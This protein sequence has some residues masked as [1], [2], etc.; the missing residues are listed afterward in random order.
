MTVPLSFSSPLGADVL[1]L[2]G[3][4]GEEALGELFAF[5]LELSSA[6]PAIDFGAIVGRSATVSI[7]LSGG[8]SR[9]FNGVV[10]RFTHCGGLPGGA[11][12][13]AELRPWLWWLTLDTDA[14]IYQQ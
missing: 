6:D 5:Q 14:R 2:Q 4:H 7:A 13:R 10:T 12:Y 1:T 9:Y 11:L 3:M 8:K